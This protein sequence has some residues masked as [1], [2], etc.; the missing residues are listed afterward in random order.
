MNA[1]FASTMVASNESLRRL[2]G[3]GA[4]SRG[5]GLDV[6]L[7][8][9]AL[10]GAIA[11]AATTPLDVLK[12]R[13]QVQSLKSAT[14]ASESPSA[15]VVR[16]DGLAEAARYT[17]AHHGV[18]GFFRGLGPRVLMMG[19]SCAISWGVYE[20]AKDAFGLLFAR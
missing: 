18:P 12:T 10:S 8:S 15:F 20:T 5:L 14:T 4:N 13:L 17:Y 1:P 9:G 6:V 19:P 3:D 16:Y 2:F 11:G 7:A